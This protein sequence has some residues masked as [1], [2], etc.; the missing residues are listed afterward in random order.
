VVDEAVV[1]P[2]GDRQLQQVCDGSPGS[3]C[4]VYGD[5]LGDCVA[6]GAEGE[7]LV[8]V[9]EACGDRATASCQGW[10]EVAG[11]TARV[12]VPH[13]LDRKREKALSNR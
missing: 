7:V 9:V 11:H 8:A 13:V 4:G 6:E 10:A 1:A 3:C 2:D 12:R 5:R